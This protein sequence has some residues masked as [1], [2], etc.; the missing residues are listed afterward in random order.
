[1]VAFANQMQ[2]EYQESTRLPDFCNTRLYRQRDNVLDFVQFGRRVPVPVN[3]FDQGFLE[4]T[5]GPFARSVTKGERR[6]LLN[7]LINAA[8]DETIPSLKMNRLTID[9]IE[10][11][12]NKIDYADSLFIPY[13]DSYTDKVNEWLREGVSQAGG[14]SVEVA[15]ST[16][17]IY[18]IIPEMGIKDVLVTNSEKID[19][20]QKLDKDTSQP[21]GIEPDESLLH[22][23]EGNRLMVYFAQHT[24]QGEPG[25]EYDEY[26]DVLFRS[27]ISQPIIE[28]KSAVRLQ[29]SPHV[30]LGEDD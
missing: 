23:N 18:R 30:E 14:T 10:N 17:N 1:M 15:G 2:Q 29:A 13:T 19:I 21:K 9:I 28:N 20:V 25:D 24:R 11:A 8:E 6:F 16:L 5:T 7:D 22:V 3:V 26:L 27:V 4:P 12:V